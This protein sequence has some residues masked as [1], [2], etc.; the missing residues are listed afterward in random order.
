VGGVLLVVAAG[1]AFLLTNR[2]PAPAPEPKPVANARPAPTA[3]DLAQQEEIL[4][5]NRAVTEIQSLLETG[6]ML[7]AARLWLETNERSPAR[8]GIT[9]SR[10]CRA[11]STAIPLA[12]SASS[13]PRS[14]AATSS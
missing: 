3:A 12:P 5:V 2:S 11:S 13:S 7:P 4:R 10:S 9:R 1:L 6:D 8:L 14:S